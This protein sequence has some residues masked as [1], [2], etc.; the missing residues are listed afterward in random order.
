MDLIQ[1]K[2]IV[3]LGAVA[4]QAILGRA[5]RLTKEHGNFVQHR[6]APSVTATIHPS[7]VLRAPDAEQ[8]HASYQQLVADLKKVRQ[9][10]G[11]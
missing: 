10:A 4:T 3:C 5:Y 11:G 9:V 2:V 7:A 6:W 8:R 1:P